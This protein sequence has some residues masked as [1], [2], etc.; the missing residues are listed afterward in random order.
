[1]NFFSIRTI[2]P[3]FLR[4]RW[5]ARLAPCTPPPMITKSAVRGR[6]LM[7]LIAHD[8]TR[9]RRRLVDRHAGGPVWA[10]L[11]GDAEPAH[12]LFAHR[13]RL[14]GRPQDV[15]RQGSNRRTGGRQRDAIERRVRSP[16]GQQP[17]LLATTT[18]LARPHPRAREPLD[19]ILVQWPVAHERLEAPRAH[20][21]RAPPEIARRLRLDQLAPR[22]LL[23][24]A[25]VPL[26]AA[27]R[28]Q[29]VEP[30]APV[31]MDF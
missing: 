16:R 11:R 6:S 2:C 7:S 23:A 25:D 9:V 19:L 22:D 8:Q 1:M 29:R 24:L 18:A 20:L 26:P 5:N 3:A 10:E 13:R 17:H 4:A 12:P 21:R 15:E 28:D 31:C 27:R 30:G 14:V